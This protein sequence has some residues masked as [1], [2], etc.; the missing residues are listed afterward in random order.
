MYRVNRLPRLTV[1]ITDEVIAMGPVSSNPAVQTLSDS[2]IIAEE[3]FLKKAMCDDFYYDFRDKKNR[4]V[5]SENK[6]ELEAAVNIGNTG[7]PIELSVGEIVNA[8]ELVS[9][10]WYKKW[11]FEFGWKLAAEAVV[12]T[13]IPTNWL[14]H[15]AS[16]EMMN[17]PKTLS[18][19]SRASQSGEL[20]DVQWKMNKM[21]QD[22][23]D[24][25]IEASHE[26]LCKH[27]EHFPLYNCKN[28]GCDESGGVSVKRKTG[29]IHG[30]YD[31]DKNN[32][33]N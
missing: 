30:I 26:W 24:P 27:R 5:T 20:K 9:D 21:H 16:G 7:D 22:R 29:W 19:E 18:M 32:C 12:Y 6:S 33:C 4:V 15:E 8:I 14:R 2:I 11:W 17:S 31:D 10:E 13:S 23:I 28:C 1:I 3:R 25:M